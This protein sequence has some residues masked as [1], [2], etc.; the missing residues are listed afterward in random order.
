MTQSILVIQSIVKKKKKKKKKD[1]LYS[2]SDSIALS[3]N[4]NKFVPKSTSEY[5][6]T[7]MMFSGDRWLS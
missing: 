7:I 4:Q 5:I 3:V 6:N 2:I 1:K